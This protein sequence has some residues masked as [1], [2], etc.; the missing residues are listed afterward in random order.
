MN[1]SRRWCRARAP[2]PSA[3]RR[4]SPSRGH[5]HHHHVGARGGQDVDERNL[6]AADGVDRE[7]AGVESRRDDVLV[8][9]GLHH[10]DAD[11]QRERQRV[12]PLFAP[13]RQ[14]RPQRRLETRA[15]SSQSISSHARTRRN[16]TAPHSTPRRPPNAS[17]GAPGTAARADVGRPHR[18]TP[19]CGSGSRDTSTI[20]SSAD[21]SISAR[22]T[23][24]SGSVLG[25]RGVHQPAA[26]RGRGQRQRRRADDA[27]PGQRRHGVG[28]VAPGVARRRA[29]RSSRGSRPCRAAPGRRACRRSGTAACRCR[30]S[31][32]RRRAPARSARRRPRR[33][34]AR[35]RA[36]ATAPARRRVRSEQRPHAACPRAR[37][38]LQEIH[39]E[40]LGGGDH[41]AQREA[42]LDHAPRR[43]AIR[44]GGGGVVEQPAHARGQRRHVAGRHEQAVSPSIIAS[45]VPPTRVATVGTPAAIDSSSAFDSASLSDGITDTVE[46]REQRRH[47]QPQAREDD[48][49]ADAQ[50]RGQPLQRRQ[51]LL[52]AGRRLRRR[53]GNAPRGCR[54]ASTAAASRNCS[55]PLRRV[56]RETTVTSGAS[57]SMPSSRRTAAAIDRCVEPLEI[58]AVRNHDDAI[59]GRTRRRPASPAPRRR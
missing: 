26:D 22:N 8:Q 11:G 35:V 17:A 5:L 23:P 20:S 18:S 31:S 52:V 33:T 13:Q 6:Q 51:I 36:R 14:A 46:A 27:R 29:A 4:S 9:V 48:A 44:R 50:T 34:P 19:R 45:G 54:A 58:H 15:A 57:G 32:G 38:P 16:A 30:T 28:D 12:D 39:V 24:S 10:L 49:V 37:P 40:L 7:R 59:G 53:R 42:L 55:S 21:V 25:Q 47:V 41:R 43:A 2:A 3:P 56:S 1:A